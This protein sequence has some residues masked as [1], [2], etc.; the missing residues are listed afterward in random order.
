MKVVILAGGYGTKIG[1]EE[2]KPKP[3]IEIGGRPILWHLMK[4]FS[5]YGFNDFLIALGYK[6]ELIKRYIVDYVTL[7][8]NLTINLRDGSVEIHDKPQQDWKVELVETGLS[9]K[10]GGRI[11]KLA[12]YLSNETFMLTWGDNL[13]NINLKEL[14]AFHRS[15]GKLATVTAV[16]PTA[17]YGFLKFTENQV[18]EFCNNPQFED[19]WMNGGFFVLEPEVMEYIE[20]EDTVWEFEPLANLAKDGQLMGYK[21]DGFWYAVDTPRE[22]FVLEKLWESNE[23]PWRV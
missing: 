13:S 8:S 19:G 7:Q 6:G 18:E 17:R 14:L 21:H 22:K 5:A 9:T 23:A 20:G 16:H 15:H 2:I 3:L 10:T 4:L 11:K 12:P 1:D